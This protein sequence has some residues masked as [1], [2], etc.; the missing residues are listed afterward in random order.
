MFLVWVVLTMTLCVGK[1]A[2]E[3][4][5]GQDS[6]MAFLCEVCRPVSTSQFCVP[7]GSLL[8]TPHES[9]SAVPL[10]QSLAPAQMPSYAPIL[11]VQHG[12]RNASPGNASSELGR[13]HDGGSP[14]RP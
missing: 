4:N 1:C 9:S 8:S 7:L 6:R 14:K 5:D 3:V 12:P 10:R 13:Q 2:G 11:A